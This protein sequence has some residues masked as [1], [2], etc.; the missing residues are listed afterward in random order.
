MK[1][2]A[3]TLKSCCKLLQAVALSRQSVFARLT[4][5]V[6]FS[7]R[8]VR[9]TTWILLRNSRIPHCILLHLAWFMFRN[10]VFCCI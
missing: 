8:G 2:N 1:Q 5:S 10:T 7:R 6:A 3:P 4:H 9:Y